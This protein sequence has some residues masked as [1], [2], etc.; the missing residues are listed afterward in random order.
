MLGPAAFMSLSYE[1][2]CHVVLVLLQR[3]QVRAGECLNHVLRHHRHSQ[4]LQLQL[5]WRP[6]YDMLQRLYA[7]PAPQLR[8]ESAA[9]HNRM[10]S[11]SRQ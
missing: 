9:S 5:P 8:G 2:L 10:M 1:L 7:A 6:L 4:H 3:R 11:A